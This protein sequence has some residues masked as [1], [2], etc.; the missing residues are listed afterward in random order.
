M[1]RKDNTI[2]FDTATLQE[3]NITSDIRIKLIEELI[4]QQETG[5]RMMKY[6]LAKLKERTLC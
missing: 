3:G 2:N 6:H 4:A 1:S 5:L